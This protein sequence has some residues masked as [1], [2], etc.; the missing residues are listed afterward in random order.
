[1][2][3]LSLARWVGLVLI[4]FGLVALVYPT[5]SD[6][7]NQLHATKLIE[8]YQTTVS[9]LSD[10]RYAELWEA[11]EAYNEKL[12]EN[13]A[14]FDVTDESHAEYMSLLD[15]TGTGIMCYL[16]IPSISVKLPVYHTTDE[17]VLQV[18]A[19]HLEG[20][21]LPIGGIGTHSAFSGHTG[22]T[23][24]KLFTALEHMETGDQF[25]IHVL[26]QTLL[27]EV[28]QIDVVLPEETELLQ[29]DSGQD[30]CT[31]ITCTPYGVNSHRLLVR[32]VRTDLP[33]DWNEDASVSEIAEETQAMVFEISLWVVIPAVLISG[34]LIFVIVQRR[35]GRR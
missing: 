31:L 18:A 20:T 7:W 28:D 5:V 22:L 30:Y 34:I 26:G 19:G 23:S 10:D 25:M 32:G 11:A 33:D 27:Y 12:A 24:A 6:R 3:R 17:S 21:S 8:T 16:E 13:P 9:E 1:M 15:I 2:K 29:I 4:L 14:R 35:K